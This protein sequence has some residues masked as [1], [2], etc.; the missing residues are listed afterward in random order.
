LIFYLF[1]GII[2][3][4]SEIVER[5]E[6]SN[7]VLGIQRPFLYF[8]YGLESVPE[9]IDAIT[10]RSVTTEL[11]VTAIKQQLCVQ[12]IDQVPDRPD[13]DLGGKSPQAILSETWAK[14]TDVPFSSYA[15]RETENRSDIVSGTLYQLDVEDMLKLNEWDLVVQPR[16]DSAS[17]QMLFPGWRYPDHLIELADGRKVST[18]TIFPDQAVDRVVSGTD[19]N[20]YLNEREVTIK[21]ILEAT[22]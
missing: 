1:C 22:K 16:H 11:G 12:E 9:V 2:L 8:G 4:M 3:F 17:G 14:H 20:P 19:Y 5:I 15:L 6:P 10:G 13:K 7:G 21:V 18:L